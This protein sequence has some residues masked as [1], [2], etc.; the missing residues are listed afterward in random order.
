MYAKFDLKIGLKMR[1]LIEKENVDFLK[2]E[3]F[4]YLRYAVD[5]SSFRFL[6]IS[7]R[8]E[9]WRVLISEGM[10]GSSRVMRALPL[11]SLGE[12]TI[13]PWGQDRK[14]S[15]PCQWTQTKTERSA[16]PVHGHKPGWHSGLMC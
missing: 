6:S 2:A 4:T 14:I 10:D 5:R 15:K 7:E 3:T 8:D 16:H 13:R 12:L 11:L 9:N 1:T